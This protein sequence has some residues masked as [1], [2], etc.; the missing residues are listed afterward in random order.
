VDE[1]IDPREL[2]P[3]ARAE[4]RSLSKD[5]ADRVARHL[6]VAGGLVD[7]EP[8]RALEHARA[9]RALAG[10]VGCVREACGVAAY[11]AGEF[12][13]ALSELR[14]ARR[15]TGGEEHLSVIADCE[16]ALGRPERALSLASSPKARAL[17]EAGQVELLI[18]ASG[19]RRDLGQGDAAVVTLQGRFLDS[20]AVQPWT[21]RLWY[22]HAEALLAAGRVE[23]AKGW[24]QAAAGLDD[25]AETDAE[26]RLAGLS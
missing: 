9:A 18:V 25:E 8:A 17:D 14:A 5:T 22:A 4:L 15:I 10:R 2:D 1:S 21:V 6:L 23:E 3:E 20:T 7:A 19:A 16:R 11:R 24:F 26:E 12:A 13:E